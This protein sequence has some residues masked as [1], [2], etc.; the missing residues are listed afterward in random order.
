M[1]PADIADG[2]GVMYREGLVGPGAGIPIDDT[3]LFQTLGLDSR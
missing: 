1:R 3:C 2:R